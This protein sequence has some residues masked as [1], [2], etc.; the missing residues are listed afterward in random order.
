MS[1][2]PHQLIS[3]LALQA[4]GL[5]EVHVTSFAA[6][7]SFMTYMITRGNSASTLN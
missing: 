5:R 3:G 1:T 6:S 4:A 2:W 7:N